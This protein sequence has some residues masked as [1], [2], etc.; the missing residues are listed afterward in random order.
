MESYVTHIFTRICI[1]AILLT[2][3]SAMASPPE[4]VTLSGLHFENKDTGILTLTGHAHNNT[5]AMLKE[6]FVRFDLYRGGIMI[7][8]SFDEGENIGPGENWTLQVPVNLAN[9]RPDSYKL[10]EIEIFN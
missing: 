7:G 5:N 6:V 3:A 8:E 1:L 10:T 2:S 4:E 9:D